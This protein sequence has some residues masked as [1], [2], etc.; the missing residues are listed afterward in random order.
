[1]N[2]DSKSS[3][4]ARSVSPLLITL[5]V[6][7]SYAL[8][9]LLRMW[10][11]ALF[12]MWTDELSVGKLAYD[13]SNDG[14]IS[15]LRYYQIPHHMYGTIAYSFLFLSPLF[16]LF[17]SNGFWFSFL[18]WAFGVLIFYLWFVL[19]RK[20][21]GD[22]QSLVLWIL[23]IAAPPF[24]IEMMTK[25]WAN[26]FESAF[27]FS[28]EILIAYQIFSERIKS[29]VWYLILGAINGFATVLCLSG[30]IFTI[31]FSAILL[32]CSVKEKNF[33]R[34]ISLAIFAASFLVTFFFIFR[35]NAT[36]ASILNRYFAAFVGK[37][38]VHFELTM[39]LDV[40]RNLPN[41]FLFKSPLKFFYP[42]ICLAGFIIAA[43][44]SLRCEDNKK[45]A[46]FQ[47][48]TLS[49]IVFVAEYSLGSRKTFSYN[50][51]TDW[52]H[53]AILMPTILFF[54]SLFIS[55]LKKFGWLFVG[56]ILSLNLVWD[57]HLK[58][59][60]MGGDDIALAVNFETVFK[61]H[62]GSDR[63][64]FWRDNL[65]DAPLDEW[66]RAL[67]R[68]PASERLYAYHYYGC[69]RGR[70]LW[71]S[72]QSL[73]S[74]SQ[75]SIPSAY[76]KFFLLGVGACWVSEQF[77]AESPVGEDEFTERFRGFLSGASDDEVVNAACAG[78][79]STLLAARY[80]QSNPDSSPFA[81][82]L[83]ET[84]DFINVVVKSCD[85]PSDE[86]IGATVL[87]VFALTVLP[88]NFSIVRT[89][90]T[91]RA[92]GYQWY[93]LYEHAQIAELKRRL[94]VE[95]ETVYYYALGEVA[96]ISIAATKRY[97]PQRVFFVS[98]DYEA[99]AGLQSA[100]NQGYMD[101]LN[102]MSLELDCS[103]YCSLFG[104]R[105]CG[106]REKPTD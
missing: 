2:A 1:M 97:A 42:L 15:S 91:H 11:D 56:L 85:L 65:I 71:R 77:L 66:E 102:L 70:Q 103:D 32:A 18:N 72:V 35:L 86:L 31:A 26:H 59:L 104:Q 41:L 74:I 78:I 16:K 5:L 6:V 33:K 88:S 3:T 43:F 8:W 22:S 46:F 27:F 14:L 67:V 28:L 101:M 51:A 47:L 84:E 80:F 4:P 44:K 92:I 90:A 93:P 19:V 45:R 29:Q 25:S 94:K 36:T 30:S 100:L 23:F 38:S 81:S 37:S 9:A 87:Q 49:F 99:S 76:K 79:A 58:K 83:I 12:D 53:F 82:P 21:L 50:T 89:L 39:V 57:T 20:I 61:L 40:F 17:G 54:V 60:R 96:A 10:A 98:P 63:L 55:R 105:L 73:D 95:N 69:A 13:L 106:L 62:K 34:F 68:S 24:Y 64:S 75:A 7:V 52:R 48:L